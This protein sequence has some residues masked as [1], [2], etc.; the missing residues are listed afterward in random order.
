MNSD[1]QTVYREYSK[2]KAIVTQSE[3]THAGTP[4]AIPTGLPGLL[5]G[6]WR[7]L[8]AGAV[9]CRTWLEFRFARDRSPRANALRMQQTSRRLLRVG[10][11]PVTVQGTLPTGGLIVSNHLGYLDILVIGSLV[12]AVFVSKEEVRGWPMIGTLTASAGTIY[13]KRES[14]RAAAE[15]NRAVAQTFKDGLPVVF[16]PEGTTTGGTELLPFQPALFDSAVK[17]HQRI[18]PVA[19]RYTLNGGDEGV[20][21]HVCYWGD[22]VFGKHLLRLLRLKGIAAHVR[23][24]DAPV[25]AKSRGEAAE[26]SH[27][28]VAGLLQELHVGR[29]IAS[30]TA[31]VAEQ[32]AAA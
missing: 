10:R 5:R 20:R 1:V 26:K 7:A 22:I 32:A 18:Q 28:V 15:V 17:S 4:T 3:I 9:L 19:L 14:I 8:Y 31:A 11:I 21:N 23:V 29:Q 25:E 16:F 2:Q 24:A 13:L 30:G 6:A 12:P 27:E